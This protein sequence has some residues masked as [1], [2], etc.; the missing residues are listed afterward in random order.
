MDSSLP[1]SNFPTIRTCQRCHKL[2]NNDYGGVSLCP[3][4]IDKD[5]ED[6]RKVKEY[7]QSHVNTSVFEVSQATG[8]GLKIIM[9][10]VREDRVQIIDTKNK[11]KLEDK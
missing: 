3:D 6:Y 2:L 1:N 10:F 9:Q 4:C 7:I 5:K 8:V 11:I